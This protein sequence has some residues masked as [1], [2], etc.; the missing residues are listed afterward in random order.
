MRP[1]SK[2]MR[3]SAR[4]EHSGTSFPSCRRGTNCMNSW[5]TADT[6]RSWTSSLQKQR[7]PIRQLFRTDRKPA[8]LGVFRAFAVKL[9]GWPP[10]A[11]L[12]GTLQAAG[13]TS[14]ALPDRFRTD[15]GSP[16]GLHWFRAGNRLACAAGIEANLRLP[17]RFVP[18]I[19]DACEELLRG[20]LVSGAQS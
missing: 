6:K 20:V 3:R 7:N 12:S 4:R 18:I 9:V 1:L 14:G 16:I 2:C 8:F 5:A 15:W 13:A 11:L 19:A 17:D 10:I